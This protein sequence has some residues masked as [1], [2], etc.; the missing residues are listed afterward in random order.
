MEFMD[1]KIIELRNQNKK[2]KL[3][4]GVYIKGE[5]I[6]FESV[7]LFDNQMEIMLPNT[8]VD[9]PKKIAQM[10]YP[11]NQRPQIIKT[12]LLGAINFSFNIFD[13][14]VTK[15]DLKQ[16]AKTFKNMI[17]KVHPANVFY[18]EKTEEFGDTKLSWFDF[19][20]YAI[21][22]QVYYIYYVT[23]INGKLLHGIFSCTRE[24]MEEYKEIAFL[25]MRSIKDISG[26][27][28]NAW[29]CC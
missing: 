8:F 13:Q 19:K 21:D 4:D 28:I 26:G 23:S 24:D 27:E 7:K 9:M 20:G 22:T 3:E 15:E 5:F 12:D 14:S 16:V 11:S 29:Y 17:K 25:V 1:E 6:A 10:K 18:E 2:I